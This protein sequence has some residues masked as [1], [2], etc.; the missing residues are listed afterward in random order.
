MTSQAY[1]YILHEV[2]LTL[3]QK[4]VGV[5]IFQKSVMRLVEWW[6]ILKGCFCNTSSFSVYIFPTLRLWLTQLRLLHNI[7]KENKN[8]KGLVNKKS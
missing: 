1:F 2:S 6:N 5:A 8:R 3:L 7:V 4:K